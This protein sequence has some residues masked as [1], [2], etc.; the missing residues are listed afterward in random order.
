MG[1]PKVPLFPSPVL[2]PSLKFASQDT[3]PH[4]SAPRR[5]AAPTYRC[6]NHHLI[7]SSAPPGVI[8]ALSYARAVALQTSA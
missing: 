5:F 4:F 1:G 2:S 8:S 6:K 3:Q 7:A